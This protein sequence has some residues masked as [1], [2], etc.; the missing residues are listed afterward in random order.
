MFLIQCQDGSNFQPG[1]AS[2]EETVDEGAIPPTNISGAY[3]TCATEVEPGQGLRAG[4]L[5]CRLSDANDNKIN[6][7]SMNVKY[8]ISLPQN[9]TNFID[10][11]VLDATNDARHDKLYLFMGKANSTATDIRA[12]MNNST[13]RANFVDENNVPQSLGGLLPSLEKDKDTLK[14]SVNVNYEDILIQQKQ[15]V[16]NGG[17]NQGISNGGGNPQFPQ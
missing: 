5:G 7:S 8:D 15:A 11:A 16:S 14:E 17:G 2:K 9:S 1:G 13:L 4:V 3:L 12:I 6:T 10:L